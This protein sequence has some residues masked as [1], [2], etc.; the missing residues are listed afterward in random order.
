MSS[1]KVLLGPVITEK[2]TRLAREGK[3]AF[4]VD[5]DANKVQIKR[6]VQERY[7][8]VTVDSVNTMVVRD[9]AKRQYTQSG[10]VQ[11]NRS[12]WKKAIV[13]LAEGEIDFFEHI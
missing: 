6:A 2:M 3:Y 13:S 4:Q 10:V 11:G 12:Y 8:E 1:N 9:K 5:M 7:P